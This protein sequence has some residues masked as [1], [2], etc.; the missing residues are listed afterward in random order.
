M[1]D[2]DRLRQGLYTKAKMTNESINKI[3]SQ[4]SSS[5]QPNFGT[6]QEFRR[7]CV[8]YV[9][10]MQVILLVKTCYQMEGYSKVLFRMINN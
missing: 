5:V 1:F 3:A 10:L 7:A 8:F 6:L 9:V 4:M 2:I